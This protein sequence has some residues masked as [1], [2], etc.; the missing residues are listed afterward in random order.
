MKRK[1]EVIRSPH[2]GY[3]FGV[4]RAM[5]L[6]EEGLVSSGRRLYSLGDVIHNPQAVENLHRQGVVPVSSLEEIE[7]HGTLIIRAHGV[8]PQFMEEARRRDIKFIDT[9]CPFVQKSQKYVRKMARESRQVLIIGDREHPEVKGI[10]GHAG[11]DVRVIN[12]ADQARKTEIKDK[13][14]IV[15]QTTFSHRKAEEIIEVLRRRIT[16]LQV[17]DTI[18]QATVL[19]REA[20]LKLSRKVDLILVVGGKESSNTRRLF[21]MCVDEG[22]NARFV[23]NAGEIDPSWFKDCERIGLTTG[24]S[25]P[26]WVLE[27]VIVR[28]EEISNFPETGPPR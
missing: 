19:R 14:G 10:C 22:I 24:T 7:D 16:D 15:I 1:L 4:K 8:D 13:A 5:G 26:D 20:T 18:C 21:Q 6:I 9:T 2:T 23:E 17:H 27:E 28:L 12:S 11:D 25:T 3:C